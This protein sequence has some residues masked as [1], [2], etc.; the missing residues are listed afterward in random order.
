MSFY[1]EFAEYYEVVFPFE[2]LFSLNKILNEMT[3]PTEF[4][5]DISKFIKIVDLF[6]YLL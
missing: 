3:E 5:A 6:G 1:S 4:S 2:M